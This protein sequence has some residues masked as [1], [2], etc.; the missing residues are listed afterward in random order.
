MQLLLLTN[1]KRYFLKA[2]VHKKWAV[3]RGTEFH[4]LLGSLPRKLPIPS[5]NTALSVKELGM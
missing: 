1:K 2:Y 4:L 3:D 5:N